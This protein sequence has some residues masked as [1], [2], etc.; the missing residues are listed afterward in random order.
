M[1]VNWVDGDVGRVLLRS[2]VVTSFPRRVVSIAGE[3]VLLDHLVA[4][5]AGGFLIEEGTWPGSFAVEDGHLVRSRS[6]PR[7]QWAKGAEDHRVDRVRRIAEAVELRL[8]LPVEPVVVLTAGRTAFAAPVTVRGVTV[9]HADHLSAW[10]G[11]LPQTTDQAGLALLAHRIERAFH[12]SDDVRRTPSWR[13]DRHLEAPRPGPARPGPGPRDW[14]P[15][16]NASSRTY[17]DPCAHSGRPRTTATRVTPNRSSGWPGGRRPFG[18]VRTLLAVTVLAIAVL[19]VPG[20]GVR[21]QQT[22][23]AVGA[24][25]ASVNRP[26]GPTT[27]QDPGVVAA[28][29]APQ[30]APPPPPVPQPV[31]LTGCS[32]LS[33]ASMSGLLGQPVHQLPSSDTSACHFGPLPG[34]PSAV[35]VSVAIGPGSEERTLGGANGTH[36]WSPGLG[37]RPTG[38]GGRPIAT[39]VSVAMDAALYPAGSPGPGQLFEAVMVQLVSGHS[40]EPQV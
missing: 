23:G 15:Y 30:P 38:P 39:Q 25:A 29:E 13:A 2:S 6:G 32:G 14:T 17:A 9:M 36:Q 18:R 5:R 24:W 31:V 10:L 27:V 22:W 37:Y 34:D 8:G 11:S 21:L 26:S 20:G 19:V 40:P 12:A 7:G 4:S 1:G 3:P 33:A 35:W 28:A 16:V